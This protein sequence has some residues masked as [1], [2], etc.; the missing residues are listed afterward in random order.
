[1]LKAR[2]HRNLK[3]AKFINN[4]TMAENATCIGIVPPPSMASYKNPIKCGMEDYR[5]ELG[6]E[7]YRYRRN[8]YKADKVWLEMW[9]TEHAET[10][11]TE[12]K[13]CDSCKEL[14]LHC[15]SANED[16]DDWIRCWIPQAKTRLQETEKQI[17][18]IEKGLADEQRDLKLLEDVYRPTYPGLHDWELLSMAWK[19]LYKS[20]E[21]ENADNAAALLIHIEEWVQLDENKKRAAKY[22]KKNGI[23]E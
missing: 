18:K 5:H 23:Y 7:E 11:T 1:M 21:E 4:P 22:R 12:E 2:P 15:H 19:S 14:H 3:K 20:K 9:L 16:T 13:T 17:K 10:R 8:F 6:V